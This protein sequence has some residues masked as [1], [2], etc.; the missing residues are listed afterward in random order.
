MQKYNSIDNLYKKQDILDLEVLVTEKIHGTSVRFGKTADGLFLVG[1]RNN[2]IF[3]GKTHYPEFDGYGFYN[4]VL[5]NTRQLLPNNTFFYGEFYGSGVQ[6]GIQY[7]PEGVKAFACFDVVRDGNFI[8]V[9]ERDELC[10]RHGIPRVPVH[11]RGKIT[12]AELQNLLTKPSLQAARNGFSDE[13]AEG[14][15][16]STLEPQYDHRGNR[17][18]A[19]FKHEKFNEKERPAKVPKAKSLN[20]A[21]GAAYCTEARVENC[22]DKVRQLVSDPIDVSHMGLILKTFSEDVYKDATDLPVDKKEARDFVKGA[23]H[24]VPNLVRA[25]LSKDFK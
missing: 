15:V 12:V 3:D 21:L 13:V 6:K 16:L 19:K 23:T 4:W 1:S 10:V 9:D 24:N 8:G 20:W 25:W 11:H 22:L 5:N 14:V 2:L 17:M 7:C 18:I